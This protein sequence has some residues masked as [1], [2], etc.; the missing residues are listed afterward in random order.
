ML[1]WAILFCPDDQGTMHNL[2]ISN[3]TGRIIVKIIIFGIEEEE[4]KT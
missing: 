4:E 3:N 1:L 2:F